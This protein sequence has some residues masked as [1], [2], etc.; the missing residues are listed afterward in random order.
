MI[1]G[2]YNAATALEAAITNQ[3]LVADNLA[4]ISTAGFRRH[5]L[6]F[7]AVQQNAVQQNVAAPST[8]ALRTAP[9]AGRS[10]AAANVP[11]GTQS[12]ADTPVGT[13]VAGQYTSFTPGPMQSTGNPFD[14]ALTGDNAFFVLDGPGG[15]VFTRN[16]VFQLNAQ[17][18]LQSASGMAVRALSG[19]ITVPQ[20]TQKI[21]IGSDGTVYG[22]GVSLGQLQIAQ[23]PQPG[24]VLQRVG[25]TLFSGP[26]PRQQGQAVPTFQVQQGYRENSNVEAVNEMVSM[27]TGM[28]HYEAAERALRALGEAVGQNTRPS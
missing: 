24:N 12:L 1:R 5:G 13:R 25:T 6:I 18:Q 16:G 2:L 20:G 19:K 27:I 26:T 17:G 21:T 9:A 22:N 3:E 11:D 14:L 7:E 15:Q 23:F 28:R 8:A 4:N 10:L